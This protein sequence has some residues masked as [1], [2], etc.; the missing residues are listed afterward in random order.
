MAGPSGSTNYTANRDE[1][2]TRA[3]RIV[4]AIGQGET[5]STETIAEANI[6]LNH[7]VKEWQADGMQL[8]KISEIAVTYT[9][10]NASY[11]IGTGLTINTTA[12]NKIFQAWNRNTTSKLDQPIILLTRQEYEMLGNKT[13]PGTP[14]QLFYQTPGSPTGGTPAIGGTLIYYPVPDTNAAS[15]L[16]G[17]VTGI[18]PLDDFL[19]STDLPDFPSYY[20]NALTWGLADQIGYE[21]GLPFQLL[22]M[23]NK[24]ADAHLEKALEFGAEEG[25]L[26]LQPD[27]QG[28]ASQHNYG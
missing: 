16:T 12:P 23:I 10:T 5:P 15:T 11:T 28:W 7:L 13:S 9:A 21:Y 3:L 25:S 22:S 4:G 26:Y 2:I 17:Y 27:W 24:K 6:T 19:A 20:Y 1:I 8:W 14:N 18:L